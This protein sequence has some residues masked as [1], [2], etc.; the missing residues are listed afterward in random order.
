MKF[1]HQDLPNIGIT[2]K[3]RNYLKAEEIGSIINQMI[4]YKTFIQREVLVGV[5]LIKYCTNI[6]LDDFNEKFGKQ[7]DVEIY[8]H[9]SE[10]GL[11]PLLKENI[12]NYN[13]IDIGYKEETDLVSIINDF[14]KS[15]NKKIP[16]NIEQIITQ[17]VEKI[18]GNI[19]K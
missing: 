14:L 18:N 17:S 1:T 15:V 11:I 12:I 16:N 4:K 19:D 9:F 6:N 2:F 3:W 7:A 13:L 8:N 5:L 10:N